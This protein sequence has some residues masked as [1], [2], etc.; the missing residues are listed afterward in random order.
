MNSL[1]EDHE[2]PENHKDL[3]NKSSDVSSRILYSLHISSS[4]FGISNNNSIQS[5]SIKTVDSYECGYPKLKH[6]TTLKQT[7]ENDSSKLEEIVI[8]LNALSSWEKSRITSCKILIVLLVLMQRGPP[9]SPSIFNSVHQFLVN[10]KEYWHS[11]DSYL[12]QFSQILQQRLVFL[13]DHSEFSK[14]FN[15]SKMSYNG[16][17][18][19][20]LDETS[21]LCI[22][23]R[24][25][26]MQSYLI[27][28]LNQTIKY[29]S[30]NSKLSKKEILT[31]Q[32]SLTNLFEEANCIYIANLHI[33]LYIY[34]HNQIFSEIVI[35]TLRNQFDE[36]F[37][38]LRFIYCDLMNTDVNQYQYL[39]RFPDVNPLDSKYPI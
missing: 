24:L 3:Q 13:A 21:I 33:L 19:P 27:S 7:I 34:N 4:L 9:I 26:S 10:I 17:T 29:N 2:N 20:T 5:V 39:G 36:Q 16:M 37:T 1:L 6:L 31:Y 25:L 28:I 35:T 38:G 14:H 30:N 22:L 11:T 18:L 8:S 12:H 15:I 32:S 23:S